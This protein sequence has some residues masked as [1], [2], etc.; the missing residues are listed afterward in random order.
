MYACRRQRLFSCRGRAIAALLWRTLLF[1]TTV[2]A[3]TGSL[4]KTTAKDCLS[5]ILLRPA[6]SAT[7]GSD[8]GLWGI[9]KTILGARPR[10]QFLVVEMR[11]GLRGA[12][13]FLVRPDIVRGLFPS[14]AVA[15]DVGFKG[16][17]GVEARP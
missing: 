5:A 15:T 12:L 13:A 17:S 1:R 14:K 16:H 11:G 7:R 6:R 3:I 10:H 4:G 9:C 8:N 2:I